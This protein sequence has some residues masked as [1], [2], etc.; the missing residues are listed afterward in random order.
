MIRATDII[1]LRT[2][3][4]KTTYVFSLSAIIHTYQTL[5]GITCWCTQQSDKVLIVGSHHDF[6]IQQLGQLISSYCSISPELP[7]I[8]TCLIIF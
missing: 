3:C 1:Q 5:L 2:A 8:R 6:K 4:K 7:V